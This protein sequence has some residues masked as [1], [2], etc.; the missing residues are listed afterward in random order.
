MQL[1]PEQIREFH[2]RGYVKIP[3]AISKAMVDT[4]RQAVNHS[5]GTLGP[6]GEDMSKHRAA[7]F[8]RDLNGAPVIMNLFNASPVISI[9]E[10]LMGEGNLQKPIRGAQVAP[11]FPT[12]IGEVPPEP[13][14]HLDGMG[15]GTNGM[16]KGVYHRGF[17]AFAVIYLADVPEPYSGNFTVWPGSHRFFENYLKCEGLETLSNGTP[18]VD[19][20]EGPDMVTGNAGDLIIAHHQMIHTGGPNASPNI[21]YAAIARLR[22]IDCDKNGNEGFQDIWREFPCVRDVLS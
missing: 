2:D 22:H 1:T 12:V 7:Q 18:R 8:C 20:P 17:T 10:S 11:R 19:L 5:I 14:G 13:R 21:R 4:A 3:G 9:A 6:N 15:T 16:P